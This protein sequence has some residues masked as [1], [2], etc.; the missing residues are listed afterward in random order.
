[1]RDTRKVGGVVVARGG[2]KMTKMKMTKR[3]ESMSMG[4]LVA[5]VVVAAGALLPTAPLWAQAERPAAADAQEQKA[6]REEIAR[7]K[8]QVDRLQDEMHRHLDKMHPGAMGSS[9][10]PSAPTSPPSAPGGMAPGG[11]NDDM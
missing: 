6:L 1:M 4:I 3:I 8:A 11:M 10:P 2:M 5:A 7:L 9:P